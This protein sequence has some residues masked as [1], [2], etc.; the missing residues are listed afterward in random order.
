M[1]NSNE[2]KTYNREVQQKF[3]NDVNNNTHTE[4]T[5]TSETINNSAVNPS[6]NSYSDGY[7]HGQVSERHHQEDV[8]V[9][10]DNN[11]AARG[12]ILGILLASLT[13]FTVGAIWLLNQSNQTPTLVTPPVV[14]PTKP[15]DKPSPE[16][17]QPPQ[18]ETII[19]R[20]RDVLVPVPQQPAPAPEASSPAPQQNT[21]TT[22]PNS[23]P[24]QPAAEK[25]P[26]TQTAPT[27]PQSQSSSTETKAQQSD[28]STTT[29]EQGASNQTQTTPDRSSAAT[30]A[31]NTG[32]SGQ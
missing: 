31:D 14:V 5:R 28:S 22:V 1:S 4:V 3:Y 23:A 9:E 16:V 19:E 32:S 2:R 8:L 10:R 29:P 21:N 17:K 11:N 12:M 20:T 25:A 26:A 7:V 18:K 27:P 6:A 15:D 30:E 13:A 24:Q